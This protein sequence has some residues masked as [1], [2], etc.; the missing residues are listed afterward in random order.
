MQPLL[1]LVDYYLWTGVKV[2]Y[3]S[4]ILLGSWV[5]VAADFIKVPPLFASRI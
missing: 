3:F 2:A 4:S 1:V 5:V